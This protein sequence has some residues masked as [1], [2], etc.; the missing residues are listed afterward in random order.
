MGDAEALVGDFGTPRGRRVRYREFV[1]WLYSEEDAGGPPGL[2][3]V[4][5]RTRKLHAKRSADVKAAQPLATP[6]G[7]GSG[8]ARESAN[9]AAPNGAFGAYREHWFMR[10]WLKG[11]LC[12]TVAEALAA[13]L[14]ADSG[15]EFEFVQAR[16]GGGK[17][18][19]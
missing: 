4:L 7:S 1:D 13:P 14:A 9:S 11:K 19:R 17:Q 2:A 5:V 12:G 8:A 3:D 18:Y 6:R 15:M 16:R 10:D